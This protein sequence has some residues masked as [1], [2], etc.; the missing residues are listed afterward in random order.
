MTTD[1]KG[2]IL[3]YPRLAFSVVLFALATWFAVTGEARFH[4]GG[5][6]FSNRRGIAVDAHGIDAVVIG[7]VLAGVGLLNLALGLR[8]PAR[9]PV[10]WTGAAALASTMLYGVVKAVRAIIGLFA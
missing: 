5:N 8:G 6:E 9:L 1:T 10:F 2:A 4:L 3:S 7:L